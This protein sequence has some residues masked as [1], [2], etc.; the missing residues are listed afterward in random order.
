MREYALKYNPD[1]IIYNFYPNDVRDNME[2][3]A[4][5]HFVLE[6]NQLKEMSPAKESPIKNMMRKSFLIL[7]IN[8]ILK[9]SSVSAKQGNS[10]FEVFRKNYSRDTEEGWIITEKVLIRMNDEAKQNNASFIVSVIPPRFQVSSKFISDLPNLEEYDLDKTDKIMNEI[11]ERNN[12]TCIFAIEYLNDIDGL[13]YEHD[14][15]FN[16]NGH[17]TYA[18]FLL[19]KIGM[20]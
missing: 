17:K 10:F 1:I 12:I 11:C 19:N 4:Y 6:N 2:R 20:V 16:E 14:Q 3:V 13:Y 7:Y 15:H 5:R 9:G 8:K 18:K